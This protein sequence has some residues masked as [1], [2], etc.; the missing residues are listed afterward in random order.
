MTLSA[1]RNVVAPKGEINADTETRKMIQTFIPRPW[2]EYGG[3]DTCRCSV[4]FGLRPFFS[5]STSL[6]KSTGP[7]A[8]SREVSDAA[9]EVPMMS[10]VLI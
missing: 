7:A 8:S 6:E 5:M 9:L 3:P 1:G 2:M 10:F 4:S